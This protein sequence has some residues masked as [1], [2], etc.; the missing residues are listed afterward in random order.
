MS[1]ELK[2][3][4]FTGFFWLLAG[5]SSQTALQV[6]V[7]SILARLVAPEDFGVISIAII[8]LGFSKIFSQLGMGAAIVQRKA[9]T[10]EHV[11]T[12]YTT[13]LIIGVFFL[14]FVDT[15][16]KTFCDLF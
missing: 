16:F 13:S 9:I 8:F 14:C 5:S 12:A 11:R 7:L 1:K 2:K 4:T 15:F 3:K 6:L 10:T